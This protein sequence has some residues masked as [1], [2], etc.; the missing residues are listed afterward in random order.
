VRAIFRE[1][2]RSDAKE[3]AASLTDKL[4]EVTDD[5]LVREN[6]DRPEVL[7]QITGIAS[8]PIVPES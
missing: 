4:R 7:E 3:L 6:K 1:Y 8:P 5:F 2:A